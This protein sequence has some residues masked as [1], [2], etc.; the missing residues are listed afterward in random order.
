MLRLRG[1]TS[2]VED[3]TSGTFQPVIDD[4]QAAAVAPVEAHLEGLRAALAE[5][6]TRHAGAI[7]TIVFIHQ[8]FDDV[9]RCQ[10]LRRRETGDG[11]DGR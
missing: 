1:A 2:S 7:A 6:L 4:P 3:F 8:Q 5:H 9:G 10:A 11:F